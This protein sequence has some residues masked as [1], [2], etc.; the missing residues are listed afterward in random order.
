MKRRRLPLR[1]VIIGGGGLA[2]A[3][4]VG[5]ALVPNLDADGPGA[6]PAALNRIA[7]ANNAAAA[8]GASRL[9]DRARASVELR[10]AQERG[11]DRA[12]ADL[13]REDAAMGNAL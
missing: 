2:V 4:A 7:R 1:W 3:I 10:A 8:E 12:D 9:R 6:P 5:L 11:R 13:R